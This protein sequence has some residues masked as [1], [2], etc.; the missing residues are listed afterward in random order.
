[1]A[2]Q[3]EL[4]GVQLAGDGRQLG[5]VIAAYSFACCMPLPGVLYSTL[6]STTAIG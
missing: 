6:A 4:V 1:M 2:E 3:I 5:K